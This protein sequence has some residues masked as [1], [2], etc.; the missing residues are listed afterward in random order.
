MNT[1][2][3]EAPNRDAAM[4]VYKAVFETWRSQ[5]D[6]SWQRSNYFA[7]FETAGLAGGWLLVSGSRIVEV[8]ACSIFSSLGIA[9]TVVWYKNN[10]KVHTYVRHWWDSVRKCE[11]ELKLAPYDFAE[12]L[13]EHQE[14]QKMVQYRE[15]IQWLPKLF[16]IGWIA[17]L[18]I[19]ISRGAWLLCLYSRHSR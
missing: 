6:S 4:E 7:A 1:S 8:L 2:G 5:V 15:L 14:K 12:K 10:K 19:A 3:G 9:L 18:V 17:L 13:E 16:G 11:K